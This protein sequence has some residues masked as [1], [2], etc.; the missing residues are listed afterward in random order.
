M[1]A[2]PIVAA[3]ASNLT[4]FFIVRPLLEGWSSSLPNPCFRLPVAQQA[5]L[6]IP[7]NQ[8]LAYFFFL[9]NEK[10]M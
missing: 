7:A 9:I 3:A 6:L 4:V 5:A 8:R 10:V 1:A 2:I